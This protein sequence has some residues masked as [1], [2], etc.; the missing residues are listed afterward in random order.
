MHSTVT[1]KELFFYDDAITL[2]VQNT[3][4]SLL[5]HVYIQRLFRT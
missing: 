5:L 1:Y 4:L 2:R 3:K